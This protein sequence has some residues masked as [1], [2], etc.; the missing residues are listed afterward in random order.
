M[1]FEYKSVWES[2]CMTPTYSCNCWQSSAISNAS[3]PQEIFNQHSVS[4][5]T[6]GTRVS[7]LHRCLLRRWT[8]RTYTS[9]VNILTI[10]LRQIHTYTHFVLHLMLW[11]RG[12]LIL[13]QT[14]PPPPLRSTCVFS[15]NFAWLLIWA[16]GWYSCLLPCSQHPHTGCKENYSLFSPHNKSVW[17]QRE[18]AFT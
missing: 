8:W 6:L 5:Y 13:P 18:A 12:A 4:Y 10:S 11:G 7:H 2:T 3:G 17:A 14:F 1:C 16:A 15:P 9:D